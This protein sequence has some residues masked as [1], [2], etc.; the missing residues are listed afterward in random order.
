MVAEVSRFHVSEQP[1]AHGIL[2]ESCS[3]SFASVREIDALW[4]SLPS[5]LGGDTRFELES[6]ERA[7]EDESSL[8]HVAD[9]ISCQANSEKRQKD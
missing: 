9:A 7:H 6:T 1:H 2:R 5:S 8:A 3:A 4:V